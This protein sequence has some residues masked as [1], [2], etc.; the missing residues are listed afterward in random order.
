MLACSRTHLAVLALLLTAPPAPA[1]ASDNLYKITKEGRAQQATRDRNGTPTLYI[2]VQFKIER[3]ADGQPAL[4]IPKEEIIVEEDRRRVADLEIYRPRAADPLTVVLALDTSG[5]MAKDRKLDEA[6]AA[7]RLFLETLHP[8]VNCGLILFDHRLRVAE[9]PARDGTDTASHRKHLAKLID[10]AEPLGGTA[11]LDATA[12]AVEMLKG[13]KGRK[14]VLLMTDGIDLNS[15]ATLPEV[16]RLAQDAQVPVYTLGVGDP[17]KGEAVTTVLVLDRSGSMAAPAA[18]GDRTPKIVALHRAAGQFVTLMRPG[19]RTTLLPFSSTVATPRNFSDNKADLKQAIERLKPDG[20][21]ALFDAIFTAIE[22]LEAAKP[23]GKRAV[24]ALTDGI[25]NVSRRR[26]AEVI[27]RAK[28]AKIPLHMLGLG[29]AKEIDA[30]VMR[31][32]ARDTGGQYHHAASEEKLIQIFE[33]LSIELHDDGFDHAS[34]TDLAAATG[35][36]FYHARNAKDLRL[37]Y[38]ELAEELQTTYTVTFPSRRP[39]HD[40]TSRGI[41]I[42]VTRG[43]L[44]VS[45]R[46]SFDYQVHGV[47]VPKMDQA[48]YLVLLVLLGGLLAL[49]AGVRRLYRF[50]GGT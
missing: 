10:E 20:E 47:V 25:D 37:Y 2:T 31:R 30:D 7:A 24:V 18:A 11:Y 19:A 40:G 32:M 48:I 41:D 26:V 45:P 14:A 22:T 5:S 42:F 4:D 36:K 28:E 29:R 27:D 9:P 23:E 46:A 15:K 3:A 21:T 6:K 12:K 17:G 35:G 1:Q 34:L 33:D 43:G 50:Y 13:V 49:P 39:Q 38:R 16:K 44:A 8:S